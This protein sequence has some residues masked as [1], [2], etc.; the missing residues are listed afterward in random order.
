MAEPTIKMIWGIAKSKELSLSDEDLH[1]LV[2]AHTGKSSIKALNRSERGTVIGV[3]KKMKD[4]ASGKTRKDKFDRGNPT[5]VNQRK[6][7]YK[8]AQALGWDKRARID[9]MCERM[10]G[11]SSVEWLN[12]MQCSKLIE[13]LKSMVRRKE[14]EDAE[15]QA[16][17][18]DEE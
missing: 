4:S 9:G 7:V 5:T 15:L 17:N 8:L 14:K 18:G 1:L 2:Q 12:Y 10:F 16:V 13:A 6:K 3:L 11:E